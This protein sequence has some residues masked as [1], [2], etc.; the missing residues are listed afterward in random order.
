MS[1]VLYC[2]HTAHSIHHRV[3]LLDFRAIITKMLAHE[4]ESVQ[5]N[6]VALS[7]RYFAGRKSSRQI[8]DWKSSLASLPEFVTETATTRNHDT[9]NKVR[10][11]AQVR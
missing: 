10:Q 5:F 2:I 6:A 11:Q 1:D 9:G 7:L 3:P 8:G 4:H